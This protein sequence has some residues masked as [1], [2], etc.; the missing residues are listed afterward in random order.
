FNSGARPSTSSAAIVIIERVLVGSPGRLQT[1]PKHWSLTSRAKP[2]SNFLK[3]SQVRSTCSSPHSSARFLKPLSW[4][5]SPIVASIHILLDTVVITTQ[6]LITR[7][8]LD[9]DLAA[10]WTRV[11]SPLVAIPIR[12]CSYQT[13]TSHWFSGGGKSMYQSAETAV[14][15]TT[16]FGDRRRT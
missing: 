13:R 16:R 3:Y 12:V 9:Q 14:I 4:A 7:Q 11:H 2:S 8:I 6:V 10:N 1:S 5:L 15:I